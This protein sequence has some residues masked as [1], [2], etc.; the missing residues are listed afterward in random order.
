MSSILYKPIERY[1][2]IDRVRKNMDKNGYYPKG[3]TDCFCVGINGD[4]GLNCPI[5]KNGDCEIEK[6]VRQNDAGTI[7]L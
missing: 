3:L 2:D 6:E 4:C 5:F 1:K 7:T